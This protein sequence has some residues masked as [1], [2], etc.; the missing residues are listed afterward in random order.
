MAAKDNFQAEK[1]RS[2]AGVT[3]RSHS[4]EG[5]WPPYKF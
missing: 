2:S 3:V 4:R 1:L 5:T